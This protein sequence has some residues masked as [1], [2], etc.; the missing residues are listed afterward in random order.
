[1]S[2]PTVEDSAHHADQN[3]SDE[4]VA[5]EP[6]LL[7]QLSEIMRLK[8]MA[9]STEKTYREWVVRYCK[10]HDFRHPREMRSKEITA[11]LSHLA[12]D[13]HVSA[14]TQNQ[15]LCAIIFLY[16]N[17]IKAEPEELE[18]MIWAKRPKTLPVVLSKEEV[19]RVIDSIDD[20][21]NKMMVRMLYGTGMRLKELIRLRIKDIDFSRNQITIRRGKGDKDRIAIL[22]QCVRADLHAQIAYASELHATDLA[23]DKGEVYMPEALAEKYPNAARELGWQYV[24]PS[25]KLSKDPRSS[26]IGRH[27]LFP[28]VLQSTLREAKAR[29]GI[30]KPVYAHGFR[31]AF[32]THLL[33]AQH[34]IRTVQELLGH[35]SLETT[36]IYT[37]VL[38]SGPS[39]VKS[40]VDCLA[41]SVC[42]P[43]PV[44]PTSEKSPSC[45]PSP[46]ETSVDTVTPVPQEDELPPVGAAFR[47]AF[48]SLARALRIPSRGTTR[49]LTRPKDLPVC[50]PADSSD[51]CR[52]M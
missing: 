46:P 17:V 12:T 47:L 44:P 36:M 9:F 5:A 2:K 42:S 32:A 6:K 20:S 48:R 30:V 25:H 26:R 28:S 15:A 45:A 38:N 33:E 8:H 3:S 31:H 24:F 18:D 1:M 35:V 16:K 40:P 41:P 13:R 4:I 14:S 34:D 37:H 11:F 7:D 29:T 23:E 39:G 27:H 52:S 21:R 22:P 43:S 51:G 19:S 10:F 49:P 50:A